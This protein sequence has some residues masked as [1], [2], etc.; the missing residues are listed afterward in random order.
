[1]ISPPP[2]PFETARN[3]FVTLEE[4]YG[5]YGAGDKMETLRQLFRMR[6]EQE[7][8]DK[9][10]SKVLSGDRSPRHQGGEQPGLSGKRV[11]KA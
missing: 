7:A 9:I 11:K 8:D 4:V 3:I 5:V 10:A 6:Q 1:M 2:S